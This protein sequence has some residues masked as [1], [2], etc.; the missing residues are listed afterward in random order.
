[1]SWYCTLSIAELH[2]CCT[3]F[4]TRGD[5]QR[6]RHPLHLFHS[7]ITVPATFPTRGAGDLSDCAAWRGSQH[8]NGI[9]RKLQSC[10][11]GNDLSMKG[12]LFG[13]CNKDVHGHVWGWQAST[14]MDHARVTG[15]WLRVMDGDGGFMIPFHLWTI[16]GYVE[17]SRCPSSSQ[18]TPHNC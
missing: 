5:T 8:E 6:A 9:S 7:S 14:N 16:R 2:F 10:Q 15:R 12:S 4:A 13:L 11:G 18:L 1:M 3:G 17:S